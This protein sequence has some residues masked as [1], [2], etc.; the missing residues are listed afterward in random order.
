MIF[1]DIN[2]MIIWKRFTKGVIMSAIDVKLEELFTY[3]K[4]FTAENG[5]SPSVREICSALKIKST[6]TCQYRLKKLESRGDIA[7]GGD[8][9]RRSISIL[10]KRGADCVYVPLI[11]TVTAGVPIFAYENLEDFY[12]L[13]PEFGEQD[14]LFMLRVRGDSMIEAG[15]YNGDKI[16]VKKTDS[17]ENGEIVVALIDES[18]TV[19]RFFKKR[20]KIILHPENPTMQDIV[21]DDVRILGTAVGLV[22]KF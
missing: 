16:I 22:R 17:A 4:D 18:A 13:P 7:L 1:F 11:G 9:K 8:N 5:Y 20:D 6:A 10:S 15:I 21:L 14:D 2:G 12:P 3:L 19:K